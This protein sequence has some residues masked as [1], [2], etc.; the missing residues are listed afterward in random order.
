MGQ[1]PDSGRCCRQRCSAQVHPTSTEHTSSGSIMPD[2]SAAG[3]R[4]WLTSPNVEHCCPCLQPVLDVGLVCTECCVTP[5]SLRLDCVSQDGF[6]QFQPAQ[7]PCPCNKLK[8]FLG[9][10]LWVC[11]IQLEG[12][13]VA[14]KRTPVLR[15]HH[16]NNV[17]FP[18][19][20]LQPFICIAIAKHSR[21]HTRRP[22]WFGGNSR[23]RK[24]VLERGSC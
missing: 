6:G 1:I 12:G 2:P 24:I 16:R 20:A 8:C 13:A 14:I 21:R 23:V 18:M 3:G 9:V 10:S 19:A 7:T 11:R 5:A 17:L 4:K 15:I 22:T